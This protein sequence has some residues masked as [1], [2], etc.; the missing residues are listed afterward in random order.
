VWS[1][2]NICK[3]LYRCR[4]PELVTCLMSLAQEREPWLKHSGVCV[5]G[6][7]ELDFFFFYFDILISS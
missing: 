7:L 4:Y 3:D 5:L 6:Q 2:W 1:I